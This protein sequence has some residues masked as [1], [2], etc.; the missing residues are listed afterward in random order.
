MVIVD[1]LNFRT[2]THVKMGAACGVLGGKM[3]KSQSFAETDHRHYNRH[4]EAFSQG[5]TFSGL[6]FEM[7]VDLVDEAL[8]IGGAWARVFVHVP[9]ELP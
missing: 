4:G 1:A 5:E 3:R 9:Q 6:P 8:E 2:E 7:A